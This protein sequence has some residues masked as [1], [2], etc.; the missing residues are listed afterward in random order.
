M[1]AMLEEVYGA[2]EHSAVQVEKPFGIDREDLMAASLGGGRIRVRRS[3]WGA[4]DRY[5]HLAV[6]EWN[7]GEETA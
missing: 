7:S 5:S 2:A 1:P 6:P 3:V 4:G